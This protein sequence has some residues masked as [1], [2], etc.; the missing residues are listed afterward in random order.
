MK[1][2]EMMELLNELERSGDVLINHLNGEIHIDIYDF[3]GFD[4]NWNEEFR[5][6]S[7][8]ELVECL[9]EVF[10]EFGDG[11]FYDSMELEGQTFVL[12]YTS[13]DI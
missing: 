5:E 2:N 4:D 1:K 3:V 8:P 11:G 6:F 12:G 7:K 10:E 9:E 13:Y